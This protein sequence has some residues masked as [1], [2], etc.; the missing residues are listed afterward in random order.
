[1]GD[2][3]EELPKPKGVSISSG[4]D[5]NVGGDVVGRDKITQNWIVHL[6]TGGS[7]TT[8]LVTLL[9]FQWIMYGLTIVPIFQFC[10]FCLAPFFPLTIGP[11]ALYGLVAGL[12][13]NDRKIIGL[14]LATG[15][16]SL[17]S[18]FL[19]LLFVIGVYA[20]MLLDVAGI[21]HILNLT[22][23]PKP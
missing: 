3:R 21:T 11:Y 19:I 18:W 10:T 22:P 20:I 15:L 13:Q 6:L 14:S 7:L 8:G 17:I 16:S 4:S 12:Q 9:I 2:E 1:M 23:T 5:V